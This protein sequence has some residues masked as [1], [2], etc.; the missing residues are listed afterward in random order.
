MKRRLFQTLL[1]ITLLTF[2]TLGAPPLVQPAVVYAAPDIESIWSESNSVTA[3]LTLTSSASADGSSTGA[4]ADASGM[5]AKSAYESWT[6]AMGNSAVGAGT[7]NT[8]TLYLKHFQSG[9]DNDNYLIE[10]YDGSVWSSVQSYTS[11]SGPPTSDITNNWDVSATI[12]TWSKVDAAQVRIIGNDSLQ[13]E[14]TVDWFVDTVELRI[15]YNP[16]AVNITNTPNTYGFGSL[17]T[18]TITETGLAYF[19]IINNGTATVNISIQGDNLT[20]SSFPWTLSDDATN[21]VDTYGLKAGISSYNVIVKSTGFN[22]LISNL[23]ASAS[24]TWGLELLAPSSY[25]GSDGP[26]SGTVTLS[27]T[28]AGG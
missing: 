4:W 11:G 24:E 1:L 18:G 7:I 2:L 26:N 21:G 25:S 22:P 14:D 8:V 5:W 28:E 10:I 16:A 15:D 27:A 20:G 23:A 12:N 3:D 19:M 9:W 17:A 6:F 13:S